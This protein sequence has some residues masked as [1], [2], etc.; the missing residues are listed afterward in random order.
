MEKHYN[1]EVEYEKSVNKALIKL[2][3]YNNN[4]Y[5]Q[6]PTMPWSYYTQRANQVRTGI[7]YPNDGRSARDLR[8]DS[9]AQILSHNKIP[10]AN[11]K[12]PKNSML[13][14]GEAL[15]QWELEALMDRRRTDAPPPSMDL[16]PIEGSSNVT[17][18]KQEQAKWERDQVNERSEGEVSEEDEEVEDSNKEEYLIRQPSQDHFQL[19]TFSNRR[20]QRIQY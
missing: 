20:L 4:N 15:Q 19:E 8:L 14:P 10:K 7:P 12:N 2:K 13:R 3:S 5:T 6:A 17:G 9:K 18:V 1:K 11:S 16:D